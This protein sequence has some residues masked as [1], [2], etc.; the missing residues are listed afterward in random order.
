MTLSGAGGNQVGGGNSSSTSG[1]YSGC[2]SDTSSADSSPVVLTGA[3][4]DYK[5]QG[6]GLHFDSGEKESKVICSL[7]QVAIVNDPN[8]KQQLA[9]NTS[10]HN[11]STSNLKTT[12][13]TQTLQLQQQQQR[14]AAPHQHHKSSSSGSVAGSS[15]SNVTAF[16]S[17]L[18]RMVNDNHNGD[19]IRWSQV[20]VLAI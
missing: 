9:T 4:D 2:S 13:D 20:S 3:N 7:K 19:L 10:S 11:H 16:L 12:N 14:E 8:N 18:W 15:S 6:Q 5:A 17:K 1:N